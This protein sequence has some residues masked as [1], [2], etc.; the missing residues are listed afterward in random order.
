[1]QRASVSR[2]TSLGFG[3]VASSS[4]TSVAVAMTPPPS[5]LPARTAVAIVPGL[6]VLHEDGSGVRG[7]VQR[8]DAGFREQ[9]ATE[10]DDNRREDE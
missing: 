7:M 1:M 2:S 4:A 8:E 3:W 10:S 5:G 9:I 6:F